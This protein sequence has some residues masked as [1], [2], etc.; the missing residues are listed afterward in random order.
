[1]EDRMRKVIVKMC[2][3]LFFAEKH[4]SDGKTTAIIHLTTNRDGC[5]KYLIRSERILLWDRVIPHYHL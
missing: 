2:Q 3:R 4:L 1:M 5:I